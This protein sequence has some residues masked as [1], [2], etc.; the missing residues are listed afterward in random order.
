MAEGRGRDSMMALWVYNVH[1]RAYEYICGIAA[2]KK[3][4]HIKM[5]MFC[6]A[7]LFPGS[8]S[9]SISLDVPTCNKQHSTKFVCN[10][11]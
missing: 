9:P 10:S 6:K 1:F 7:V 11:K 5:P 2:N 4:L 3:K 8:R